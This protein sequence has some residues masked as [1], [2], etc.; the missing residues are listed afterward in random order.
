MRILIVED[1]RLLADAVAE[2]L[3]REAMAVDVAYDGEEASERLGVNDYDV[4][5]LDRDLPGVSGDDLCRSLVSANSPTRVLMLTAAAAVNQRVAGL[6]LGADDYLGKP[7]DFTELVARV[8]ALGRRTQQPLSPVLR[9]GD[10]Q[11]DPNRRE[12]LRG[13]RYVRLSR[14]EFAVLEE[15]LRATGGVVTTERLLEKAWDEHV[16]PFTNAVR[17]TMVSLRRKLG[18]PP[19]VETVHGVG[20]RVP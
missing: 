18:E 3:R 4:V 7:F 9:R 13:G 15:L 20:Y 19:V 14:K 8:R 10:V 11:L 6:S 2:G 16:N 12:V 17:V 5:V 1:Q